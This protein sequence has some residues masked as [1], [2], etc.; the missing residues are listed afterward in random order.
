M[1]W[2]IIKVFFLNLLKTLPLCCIWFWRP[3]GMCNLSPPTTGIKTGCPDMKGEVLTLDHQEVPREFLKL[4]QGN[5]ND[6]TMP[7]SNESRDTR[8]KVQHL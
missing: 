6:C 8:Q 7:T 4:D 3:Q 2:T 5:V 1:I